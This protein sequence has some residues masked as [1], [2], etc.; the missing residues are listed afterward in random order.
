M[1][2]LGGSLQSVRTEINE[3]LGITSLQTASNNHT[4]SIMREIEKNVAEL[5]GAVYKSLYNAYGPRTP[6][7]SKK[8]E[9][10]DKEKY[11][12]EDKMPT[13]DDI[14]S[15][16]EKTM[17]QFSDKEDMP[18]AI[19]PDGKMEPMGK[20]DGSDDERPEPKVSLPENSAGDSPHTMSFIPNF[21]AI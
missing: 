5:K 20:G 12:Y 9:K 13:T 6:T 19:S 4:E 7:R 11:N 18:I 15:A 2:T 16:F 21:I 14:E 10:K 3:L 1:A 17:G 8:D